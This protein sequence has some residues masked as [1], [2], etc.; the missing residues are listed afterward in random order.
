MLW[1]VLNTWGGLML[2]SLA[3]WWSQV[4]DVRGT[5][6]TIVF[7]LLFLHKPLSSHID[8]L[9][10]KAVPLRYVVAALALWLTAILMHTVHKRISAAET[11]LAEMQNRPVAETVKVG[12]D[13][14]PE[15]VAKIAEQVGEVTR[16]T[17]EKR[18]A[19]RD[20]DVAVREADDLRQKLSAQA[21]AADDNKKRAVVRRQ[22]SAYMERGRVLLNEYIASHAS[23]EL[24]KALNQWYGESLNY[25]NGALGPDYAAQFRQ[26]TSSGQGIIGF[27]VAK[28][29]VIDGINSRLKHLSNFIDQLR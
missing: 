11:Q 22:L 21:S 24:E 2:G 27:P 19:E 5:I 16:L 20:R 26:T 9:T 17:S 14:N 7:V 6:A 13:P 18:D 12:I 10:K 1:S 23:E 8:G 28:I 4:K 3:T 29:G 25:V 15:L